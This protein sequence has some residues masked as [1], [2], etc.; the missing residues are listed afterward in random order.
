MNGQE[1]KEVCGRVP[2]VDQKQVSTYVNA[3]NLLLK[4][5]ASKSNTAKAASDIASS[6]KSPPETTVHSANDFRLKI[7][8]FQKF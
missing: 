2:K 4:S 1:D 5:H 8:S 3:E 7:V 6:K